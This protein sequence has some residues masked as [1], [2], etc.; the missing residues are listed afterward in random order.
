[1]GGTKKHCPECEEV[2]VCKVLPTE[3]HKNFFRYDNNMVETQKH[4]D[5][6]NYFKRRLQCQ[7]CFHT[8]T[9]AEVESKHLTELISIRREIEQ[10]RDFN[11][12]KDDAIKELE[13]KDVLM[14]T[15][16]TGQAKHLKE[17]NELIEELKNSLIELTLE[18]EEKRGELRELTN[19]LRVV[20]KHVE[21]EEA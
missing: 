6:I 21:T 11:E 18:Y 16:N 5:N 2:R 10:L 3:S 14:T 8:W 12:T 1:M 17:N 4:V 15:L 9:T 19:A 7:T 20:M 13:K